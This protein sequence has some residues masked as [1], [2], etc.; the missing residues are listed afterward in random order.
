[1]SEVL[2]NIKKKIQRNSRNLELMDLV[3]QDF[4]DLKFKAKNFSEDKL[5][6]LVNFLIE[7]KLTDY[8]IKILLTN[9]ETQ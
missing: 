7:C 5:Q 6:S 4:D 2:D 3:L 9:K 1:M 8:E